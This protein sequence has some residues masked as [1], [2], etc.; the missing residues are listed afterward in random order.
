M[1]GV[2]FLKAG[3]YET[4]RLHAR[5]NPGASYWYSFDY[6]GRHQLLGTDPMVP[7]G[8][9]NCVLMIFY[10]I[11]GIILAISKGVGHADEIQYLWTVPFPKNTSEMDLCLRMRETWV[12]F[13]T[14][15]YA[16][17]CYL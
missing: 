12:N 7:P 3:G 17:E 2:F 6:R 10:S 13:I 14:S 4:V 1:G 11:R 5:H 16:I 8:L 15:G 9:Y